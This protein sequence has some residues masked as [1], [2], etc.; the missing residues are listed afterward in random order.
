MLLFRSEDDVRPWCAQRR[1]TP[2]AIFDLAQLWE[3]ARA[4]YDDRLDLN[5]RR[6]TIAERQAILAAVGLD[7]PFWCLTDS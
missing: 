4:W 3:L 5:W 6:R 1:M 7:G 2:G